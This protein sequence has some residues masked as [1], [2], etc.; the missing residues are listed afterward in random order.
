MENKLQNK[1]SRSLP[2]VSRRPTTSSSHH[3]LNLSKSARP[4]DVIECMH[5]SEGD[6]FPMATPKEYESK[7][8]LIYK[9]N[10][11]RLLTHCNIEERRIL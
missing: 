7:G 10:A 1:R 3:K 5:C 6:A 8:I 4:P 2:Q 11:C 9:C